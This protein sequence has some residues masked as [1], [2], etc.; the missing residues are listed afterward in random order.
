[1]KKRNNTFA[2]FCH[3][4]FLFGLW[5]FVPLSQATSLSSFSQDNNKLLLKRSDDITV[6]LTAI[7]SGAIEVDYQ[8]AGVQVFPPVAIAADVREKAS[9]LSLSVTDGETRLE[10]NSK[11]MRV[12]VQ[13]APFHLSFYQRDRLLV[14]EAAGGFF[15]NTLRGVQF[16]LTDDEKIYGGGQRVLG[17]DRRGNRMPLYNRAS[18]GYTDE[19]VNQMYF[20]LPAVMSSNNY[21]ILF[22]NTAT[23]N[24]DIGSDNPDIL[25][26]DAVGGRLAYVVIANE[27]LSGLVKQVVSVT[28][29]QPLPPRWALGNFA[30]RFGYHTEQETRDVVEKFNQDN[31]PLDAVVLDL[32]WFGKDIQGHMGNLDW[33]REAFPTP[34]DMMAD[35]KS[36]NVNTVV[37]TEPFILS[38]SSQFDSAVEAD[39]LAKRMGVGTRKFDFYFGNT[40][41]VDVFN[42]DGQNWFWQYYDKLTEQGVSGWWGDLGE[43][44]VHPYDSL[45]NWNGQ[46]VTAEEVHNAFGHHWA[47]MVYER[48]LK[49]VPDKRPLVLMRAGFLGSQR[50]GMIPWTGDVSRS[51]GGFK[52]QVELALQMSVFGLAYTHSD[53]GGFA[54]GEEFD[55][56]LYIRWLQAGTFAPVY[57]PHAQENIAPEPVFHDENTK[58]AV[59]K[60]IQLR[61][62]MLPYNYSLAYENSLTGMPLMRPLAFLDKKFFE[63]K[64]AYLWGDSLLIRPVTS[65]GVETADIELPKGVWFDFFGGQRF[66]GN[67][68]INYAAPVDKLPVLVKA[69][70]FIPMQPG[71]KRTAHASS[72]RLTMHYWADSSVTQSN[73][74]LYEDAGNSPRAIQDSQYL[75]M[76]FAARNNDK[77]LVINVAPAGQYE[78]LSDKREMTFIVHGLKAEPKNITHANLTASKWESDRN[79]LLVKVTVDH[80]KSS[81]LTIK[82]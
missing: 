2:W 39:A 73:Y 78:G 21:A 50:Y 19:P 25:Q 60:Y 48:T 36:E 59:R 26:F 34:E 20:G 62:D 33:D 70:A 37:I 71:I 63:N 67:Q 1:M 31:I 38:T 17:M 3:W 40:G 52:P 80:K 13:K 16:R 27:T 81:T 12:V 42:E 58:N 75:T 74:R 15:L 45:H 43:P 77:D 41:L 24:L 66:E 7:A 69:G 9:S 44:E 51:W 82:K 35:F 46:T 49:A 61:Y 30:S 56:E 79:R 14:E 23:G 47:K 53:L 68:I 76:D 64:D 28:G 4:L 29:K 72:K 54:G 5:A 11:D 22:D 65:P 18:Y 57:R 32:Y 10:V 8:K 6:T 55:P